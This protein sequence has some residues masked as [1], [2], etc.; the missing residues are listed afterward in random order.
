MSLEEDI[1]YDQKGLVAL[2]GEFSE[3]LKTYIKNMNENIFSIESTVNEL[4]TYWT[5]EN[6]RA[7]KKM[8]EGGVNVLM[9]KVYSVA[10]LKTAIDKSRNETEAAL[11]KMRVRFGFN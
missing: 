10:E 11:D 7:Y 2:Y 9:D 8:M 5:D 6:Y 1:Y 3:K 4:N